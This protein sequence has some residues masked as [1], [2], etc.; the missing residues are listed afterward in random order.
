MKGLK[1]WILL[2]STT[3]IVMT[4]AVPAASASL[5][6]QTI[7]AYKGVNI[8][9]NGKQLTD[10][11]QPYVI[12]NTTYIPLRMLM[13]YFGDKETTWDRIN[14]K[15]VITDKASSTETALRQ[16]L[17]QYQAQIAE[18]QSKVRDLESKNTSLT[19]EN[20]TLKNRISDLEDE[21]EEL[22]DKNDVSLDDI[23]DRLDDYFEDAGDDYFG[24][25]GI[26]ITFTLSGDE[27]DL[28]YKATFSFSG[29]DEY[30]KLTELSQSRL[31]SFLKAVKSKIESE[32]EDTDYEDADITG[33][34][35]DKSNSS[36]YVK[37]DGSTYTFSWS[38]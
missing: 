27:D 28:V 11:N 34:A 12:N 5:A 13:N 23:E 32:I 22:K 16:Q 36:Y 6:M 9:Y 30:E 24:D 7:K 38:E 21:I 31:K 18:L 15:V 29:A 14:Q 2:V 17:T 35:V 19:N 1:K 25:D 10:S 33:K 37:Y 3:F 8:F 20:T 26:R 4:F